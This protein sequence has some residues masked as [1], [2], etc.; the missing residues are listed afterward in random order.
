MQVIILQPKIVDSN[1]N[2]AQFDQKLFVKYHI[3]SKT[4]ECK[5]LKP[6]RVSLNKLSYQ[7]NRLKIITV[8]FKNCS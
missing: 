2:I 8:V 1:Y 7:N 6:F 5:E 3:I 4:K